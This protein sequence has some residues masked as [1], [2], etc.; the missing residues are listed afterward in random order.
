MHTV[1]AKIASSITAPS[2]LKLNLT[3]VEAVL[4]AHDVKPRIRGHRRIRSA[5][6][7][8]GVASDEIVGPHPL[9]SKG[10]QAILEVVPAETRRSLKG[11]ARKIYRL[12]HCESFQD[13]RLL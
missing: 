4:F 7:A 12:N 2:A 8:L 13:R 9:G 10:N 1:C 11:G 3:V 6:A 5:T